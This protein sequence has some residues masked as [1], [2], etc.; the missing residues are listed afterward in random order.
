[1]IASIGTDLEHR[2]AVVVERPLQPAPLFFG[3]ADEG[4]TELE[5]AE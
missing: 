2:D 5:S 4:M 3:D 1:M